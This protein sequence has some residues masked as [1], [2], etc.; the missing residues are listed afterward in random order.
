MYWGL[1]VHYG[2]GMVKKDTSMPSYQ[3]ISKS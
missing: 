3:V 1:P 2:E